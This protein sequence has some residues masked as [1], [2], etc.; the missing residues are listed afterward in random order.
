M[1]LNSS[2]ILKRKYDWTKVFLEKNLWFEILGKIILIYFFCII[3][4]DI[5]LERYEG[6]FN[7]NFS[8]AQYYFTNYFN[9]ISIL[10]AS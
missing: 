6:Y 2:T 10:N 9:L 4:F 3:N 8:M 7:K 5:L 1:K